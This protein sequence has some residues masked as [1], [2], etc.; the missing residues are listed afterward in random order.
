MNSG[1]VLRRY[2][3]GQGTDETL[4]WYEGSDLSSPSWLAT[5]QL[6]SVI[7]TTNSSGTVTATYA[8]SA[9]GEPSGG[10]AS[11]GPAFRYT[12]QVQLAA[13]GLYYYKARM[14]DPA[15]GRFL[16]TDP[17]GYSAGMNLYAYVDDD[18]INATDPSGLD[19][20]NN[21]NPY[22]CNGGYVG[23]CDV[24]SFGFWS[25]SQHRNAQGI[26]DQP[27]LPI[28][29]P[30]PG[31]A[32]GGFLPATLITP[33]GGPPISIPD[34]NAVYRLLQDA[35]RLAQP[36][37]SARDKIATD[38]NVAVAASPAARN[39]AIEEGIIFIIHSKAYYNYSLLLQAEGN[40][41]GQ[42]GVFEYLV[43][44]NRDFLFG[45]PELTHQRF[46]PGAPISGF[47]NNFRGAYPPYGG[48]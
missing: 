5:D 47:P 2:V 43:P 9:T 13:V 32:G 46:I 26:P 23:S 31:G 42:M 11:G 30:Y 18:P 7:A 19:N 41:G 40:N 45:T 6:G 35:F 8:Y 25:V 27:P 17:V 3:P 20:S 36:V 34:A 16:Q 37:G 38:P 22:D 28:W 21:N 4:V 48:L 44:I 24:Y 39:R 10:F 1:N 12:G 33:S 29:Q 14:Y 15:L